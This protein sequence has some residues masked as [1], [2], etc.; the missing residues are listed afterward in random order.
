MVD[1]LT[2]DD[3]ELEDTCSECWGYGTKRDETKCEACHG[4]GV[5]PTRFGR[6]ILEFVRAYLPQ[7]Q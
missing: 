7:S 2:Q 4:K 6:D 5:V 3:L 1:A